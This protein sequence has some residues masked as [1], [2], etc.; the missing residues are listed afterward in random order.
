MQMFQ[1]MAQQIRRIAVA[2]E[3]FN[4]KFTLFLANMDT[5]AAAA[6]PKQYLLDDDGKYLLDDSGKRIYI[7]AEEEAE[8]VTEPTGAVGTYHFI[9]V[10][11]EAGTHALLPATAGVYY[12]VT[13]VFLSST[14]GDTSWKLQDGATFQT[15]YTAGDIGFGAVIPLA[16]NLFTTTPGNALNLVVTGAGTIQGHVVAYSY[17]A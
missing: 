17:G 4:A 10:L 8:M 6:S 5:L 16:E 3:G 13:F 7:L 9:P 1:D 15:G 2:A 12:K 11:R 14:M